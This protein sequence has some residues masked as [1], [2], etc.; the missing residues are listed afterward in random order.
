MLKHKGGTL[1]G[2]L[3]PTMECNEDLDVIGVKEFRHVV[4][5]MLA[6]FRLHISQNRL[7]DPLGLVFVTGIGGTEVVYADETY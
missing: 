6:Y 7:Y 2:V 1:S 4:L 5:L 3:I